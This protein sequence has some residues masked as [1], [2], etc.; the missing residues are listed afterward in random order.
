MIPFKPRSR[1]IPEC[2]EFCLEQ[3]RKRRNYS[4]R[5]RPPGAR[6]CAR[7]NHER[8]RLLHA[9][10]RRRR[11]Q[12]MQRKTFCFKK[13]NLLMAIINCCSTLPFVWGNAPGKVGLQQ[14]GWN[15]A[16]PKEAADIIIR[17]PCCWFDA[18]TGG[19]PSFF[20]RESITLCL[21]RSFVS[22]CV[23]GTRTTTY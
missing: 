22:Q 9:R 1:S 20:K 6:N 7:C 17:C 16:S 15:L 3:R 12:N 10:S 21:L 4:Q 23:A 5:C 8:E 18:V 19:L 13:V 14:K 2:Y 11:Q